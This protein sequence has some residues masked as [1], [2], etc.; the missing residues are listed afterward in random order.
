MGRSTRYERVRATRCRKAYRWVRG[1]GY[2]TM[3]SGLGMVVYDKSQNGSPGGNLS[4]LASAGYLCFIIAFIIFAC[5]YALY[6][7]IRAI[8]AKL[9]QETGNTHFAEGSDAD[10]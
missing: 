10:S 2:L 7:A 6:I 8:E 3:F 5:S 9:V 4:E 1:I